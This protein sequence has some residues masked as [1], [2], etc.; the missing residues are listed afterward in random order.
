VLF[1]V[2]SLIVPSLS[3]PEVADR[4][5]FNEIKTT[6]E[7]FATFTFYHRSTDEHLCLL[8][9]IMPAKLPL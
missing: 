7:P 4:L 6:N 3:T 8:L 9:K 1:T 5:T 2:V